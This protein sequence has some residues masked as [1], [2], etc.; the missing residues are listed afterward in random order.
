MNNSWFWSE[1]NNAE[2]VMSAD[3]IKAAYEHMVEQS[4]TLVVSLAPGKAGLLKGFDVE[5]L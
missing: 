3:K 4:S 2:S 1:K 5:A